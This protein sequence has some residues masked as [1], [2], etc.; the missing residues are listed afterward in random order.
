M[1]TQVQ[2]ATKHLG[3]KH[4]EKSK[5]LKT[6]ENMIHITIHKHPH[7]LNIGEHHQWLHSPFVSMDLYGHR[8]DVA[9]GNRGHNNL[10]LGQLR[11]YIEL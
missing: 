2:S 9:L 4:T 5:H 1:M 8:V 10:L 3:L 11:L 7:K 6:S